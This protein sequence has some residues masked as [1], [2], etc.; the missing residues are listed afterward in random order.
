MLYAARA[1]LSEEELNAKTHKGTWTLFTEEY[2]EQGRVEREL[3]VDAR[4]AQELREAADYDA[5]EV[6]PGQAE[7]VVAQAERFVTAIA[8]LLEG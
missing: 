6:A 4:E 8:A 7:T 5:R 2:V 1:A 3:V